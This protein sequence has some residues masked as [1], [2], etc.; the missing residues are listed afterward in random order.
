MSIEAVKAF[1][2][3]KEVTYG[4]DSNPTLAA[5][6]ILTRNFQAQPIETDRLERH[7]DTGTWGQQPTVATNERQSMTFEVEMAGSGAAGTA[8]R[9]MT[10]LE[11]CGMAAPTLTASVDAQQKFAA[12]GAAQ[13]ALSLRHYV[14]DQ[15]RKGVGARGSWTLDMTAG[16]TPFLSFSLMALIPTS[17]PFSVSAPSG[18]NFS[19]WKQPLEVNTLNTTMLLD[20]YAMV[21]RSLRIASN[22]QTSLRNLVGAR[23]INR[24]PHGVTAEAVIEAPSVAAKDYIAALRSSA[25]A[26]LAVTHGTI[27]GNI[28]QINAPRAQV[29]SIAESEEDSKLMWTL[30]LNLTVSDAGA[31]ELTIIAK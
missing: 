16:A 26:P 15:M 19:A 23:Y 5:D 3:K 17:T 20:S 27:A 6:A 18:A 25:I 12:R 28:V 10:L 4:T 14:G 8:P 13:T 30:G 21:V 29:A 9:W 1:A 11:A 22:L 2:A 7:L 24:G 31:D